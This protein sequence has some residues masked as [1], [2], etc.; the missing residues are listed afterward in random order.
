M[1]IVLHPCCLLCLALVCELVASIPMGLELC[2]PL[3]RNGW[4]G[5]LGE[6]IHR[7]L[8][9]SGM[10]DLV[11]LGMLWLGT[12][13]CNLDGQ[14]KVVSRRVPGLLEF[15]SLGDRYGR[16]TLMISAMHVSWLLLGG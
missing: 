3:C 16:G 14:S 2:S 1:L 13:L 4:E 10:T 15:C 5:A 8:V 12:G 6:W 9:V 7:L 11:V